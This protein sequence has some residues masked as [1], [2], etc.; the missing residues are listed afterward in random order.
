MDRSTSHTLLQS[1]STASQLLGT[2]FPDALLGLMGISEAV[3]LHV[4]LVHLGK[5]DVYAVMKIGCEQVWEVD[6][7]S[8][9]PSLFAV[10]SIGV[11]KAHPNDHCHQ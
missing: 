11:G 8:N 5:D 1:V 4:E 9:V 10:R 3:A 2:W 6:F 7:A